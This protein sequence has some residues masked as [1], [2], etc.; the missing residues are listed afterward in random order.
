M[1]Q[2]ARYPVDGHV[3]P[4]LLA[5]ALQSGRQARSLGRSQENPALRLRLTVSVQRLYPIFLRKSFRHVISAS[6]SIPFGDDPSTTPNTPRPRSVSATITST[7]FAVAQKILH[8]SGTSLI[9]PST[10]IG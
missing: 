6:V 5:S 3:P 7:G 9:R 8:T 2:V 10:L 1:A 4:F